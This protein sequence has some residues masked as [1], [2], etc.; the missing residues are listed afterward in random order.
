MT[1]KPYEDSRLAN[2]VARRILELKPSKTQSEIAAQAGFVNP[3]MITMIKQGSNKAA[4]DRIPALARA[5][6]VD[7]AY[8]MGLALEQAIGRTAAEAVIE[9][10]GDPVTE[11]ELGWIKAIREASGHSDPRLTT[12]CVFH[13]MWPP[14]PRACGQSFH[15]MWP[16]P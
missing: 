14:V 10:F 11:N 6:E 13:D 16:H 2:Y 4:L 5:L 3:N 7:P 9:I 8:L 1:K 12:R 15:D